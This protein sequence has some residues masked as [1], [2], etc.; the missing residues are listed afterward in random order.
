MMKKY[1]LF[2][3]III[4]QS[5]FSQSDFDSNVFNRT[6]SLKISLLD[7][8]E[9]NSHSFLL[10]YEWQMGSNSSM[11]IEAGPAIGAA[12]DLGSMKK[13]T[14]YKLRSEIRRWGKIKNNRHYFF[15]LQY[16]HKVMRADDLTGEFFGYSQGFGRGPYYY[17][18]EDYDYLKNVNALHWTLG[19]VYFVNK[20]IQWD[21]SLFFGFRYKVTKAVGVQSHLKLRNEGDYHILEPYE[22]IPFKGFKPSAGIV[23]RLGFGIK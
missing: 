18:H 2:L 16:M 4:A 3:F 17:D 5:C 21:C 1:T 7:A 9:L 12:H 15:G 20:Y 22:E 8:I 23:C 14:G 13:T 6:H 10:S 11:M 19:I